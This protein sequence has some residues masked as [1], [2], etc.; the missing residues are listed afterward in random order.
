MTL[1]SAQSVRLKIQDTPYLGAENLLGDGT[2]VTFALARRNLSSGSAYVVTTGGYSATGATFDASGAVTFSGRISANSAFRVTYVYSTF[3]DDE[4]DH[5]LT[6]G[7]SVVGAALEA[8][9]ALAFDGL[10][11]ASWGAPDGARFDDTAAQRHVMDLIKMLEDEERE[12]EADEAIAGGSAA[13]WSL[14]QGNY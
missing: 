2:A 6:V 3:S 7:K 1:T 5:F 4:I 11:R 13:S 9:H 14:E 12:D 8:A 10:R